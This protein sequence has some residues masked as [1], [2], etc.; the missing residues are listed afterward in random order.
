MLR[1]HR[2]AIQSP[3]NREVTALRSL[4]PRV[5]ARVQVLVVVVTVVT[6]ILIA[7]R[8]S[9]SEVPFGTE[10]FFE[11]SRAGGRA[12]V[13]YSV[14]YPIVMLAVIKVIGTVATTLRAF[15][16][17]VIWTNLGFDLCSAGLIRWAWGMNAAIFFLV[18]GLPM[19]ATD[20][21]TFDILSV[22]LATA[23]VVMY[24]RRRLLSGGALA[25]VAA[26]TKIWPAPLCL[27]GVTSRSSR[28]H[29]MAAISVAVLIGAVWFIIGG[30]D[31]IRQVT[32]ARDARGWEIETLPGA[33]L[34][35]LGRTPFE[36]SGAARVGELV[37]AARTLVLVVALGLSVW[38][39]MR[40]ARRDALGLGWLTSVVAL[41]VFSVLLSPQFVYWTLPA[42]AIAWSER[43]R[44]V[45]VTIAIAIALTAFEFRHWSSILDGRP[46]WL[47]VLVLRNGML[48]A[49]LV[50]GVVQLLRLPALATD[51]ESGGA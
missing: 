48:V 20:Y 43:R 11:I 28:R 46:G 1:S 38:S 42:G 34:M 18:A 51:A 45:P 44:V 23:A 6:R 33:V 3:L 13:D 30:L 40:G 21:G 39:L 22:L 25:G 8:L 29:A 9:A 7:L 24:K 47:A 5:S 10:R 35:M 19:I 12:Y 32:S 14:E 50:M 15:S 41:L 27:L 4:T 2:R 17:I 31:G 49:A 37:P 36:Q 26:M 16:R